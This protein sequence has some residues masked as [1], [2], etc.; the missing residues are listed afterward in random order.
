[1]V[2]INDVATVYYGTFMLN[3]N[4]R[5]SSRYSESEVICTMAQTVCILVAFPANVSKWATIGEHFR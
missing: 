1:M 2:K 4:S 3:R 5:N